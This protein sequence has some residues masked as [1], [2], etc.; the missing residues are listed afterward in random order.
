M[1]TTIVEGSPRKGGGELILG[2]MTGA[3]FW[4]DQKIFL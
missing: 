4:E 3:L 2:W 1:T